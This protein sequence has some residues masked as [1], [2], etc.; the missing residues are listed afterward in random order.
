MRKRA[1]FLVFAISLVLPPISHA[2]MVC[3]QGHVFIWNGWHCNPGPGPEGCLRCY[4]S[5]TVGGCADP[6]GCVENPEP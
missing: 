5:I 1:L 6:G 2:E 4:D 3:E